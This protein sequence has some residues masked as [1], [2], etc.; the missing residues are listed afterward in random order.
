MNAL[1]RKSFVVKTSQT[2]DN[3]ISVECFQLEDY[4]VPNFRLISNEANL[5]GDK[6]VLFEESDTELFAP[7][8]H[9]CSGRSVFSWSHVGWP[10][11]CAWHKKQER[12]IHRFQFEEGFHQHKVMK[13]MI[14]SFSTLR[15]LFENESVSFV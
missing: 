2:E 1:R 12:H 13:M 10:R 11:V 3:I 6:Q 7:I 14:C 9:H 5:C 4:T 8:F 15:Y